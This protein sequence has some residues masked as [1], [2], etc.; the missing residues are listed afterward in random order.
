LIIVRSVAKPPRRLKT[1]FPFEEELVVDL[2]LAWM[3]VVWRMVMCRALPAATACRTPPQHQHC[4]AAIAR[5]RGH[6]QRSINPTCVMK[7][8]RRALC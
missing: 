6:T 5:R 3:S 4:L 2:E 1:G 7:S 8:R